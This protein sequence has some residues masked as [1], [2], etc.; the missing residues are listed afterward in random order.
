VFGY[1][2]EQTPENA[3]LVTLTKVEKWLEA[4]IDARGIFLIWNTGRNAGCSSGY[5]SHGVYYDSCSYVEDAMRILD[6]VTHRGE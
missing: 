3:E 6:E 4:G 2:A 1:V 5:N